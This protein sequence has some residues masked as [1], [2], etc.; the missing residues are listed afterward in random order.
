MAVSLPCSEKCS[1]ID[2]VLHFCLNFPIKE[3]D[4]YENTGI[5]YLPDKIKVQYHERLRP[6]LP[7]L[8]TGNVLLFCMMNDCRY[9]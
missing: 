5:L 4:F 9:L 7:A 1:R 6:C 3:I 2:I 8:C